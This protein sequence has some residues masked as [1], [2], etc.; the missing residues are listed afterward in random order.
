MYVLLPELWPRLA[1]IEDNRNFMVKNRYKYSGCFL[2]I[3][4]TIAVVVSLFGFA[5]YS[6]KSNILIM[7]IDAREGEGDLGRTD[8]M[9]VA[10]I[11]PHKPFVGVLSIPRDLWVIVPGYGEN[12]INTAHFF[13]E[14]SR[15]GDGPYAAMEVVEDNFGIK[16]DYFLRARFDSL[17]EVIDV[18]GGVK[19]YLQEPMSGYSAGDHLLNGEQ[20]LA[21]VRDRYGS[22]DFFRM[23]RGQ[24]VLKAYLSQI[25]QIHNWKHI[26]QVLKVFYSSIDSNIPLHVWPQIII[27]AFRTGIKNIDFR[28]ISRDMVTPFT[29]D[30]GAAVLSPNWEL[31][32]PLLNEI[33]GQ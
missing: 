2:V 31:I 29:S 13:A 19:I 8:T 18:I 16:L 12:R 20:A 23:T 5:Y 9:I 11:D 32:Q 10:S 30:G 22:D 15:P 14:A 1:W 17:V 6:K 24:M 25:M 27:T 28:V 3:G 4:I 21:F 7:G 26:P 33:F